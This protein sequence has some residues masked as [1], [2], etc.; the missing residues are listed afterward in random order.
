MDIRP[1]Y[2]NYRTDSHQ[3]TPLPPQ[4]SFIISQI[5]LFIEASWETF[6]VYASLNSTSL[7]CNVQFFRDIFRTYSQGCWEPDQAQNKNIWSPPKIKK[8]KEKDSMKIIHQIFLNF[9]SREKK[10]SR[11]SMKKT[12]FFQF[13]GSY[14]APLQILGR[15]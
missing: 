5:F 14:C 11:Q 12:T 13:F 9:R 2:F 4:A 1:H 15:W 10:I 7:N 3:H 8:R 6:R